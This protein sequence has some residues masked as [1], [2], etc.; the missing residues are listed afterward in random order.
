VD[1]NKAT[2][3]TDTDAGRVVLPVLRL[4]VGICEAADVGENRGAG[5]ARGSGDAEKKSGMAYAAELVIGRD[6]D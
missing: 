4:G 1:P 3:G 2:K 5:K 6:C